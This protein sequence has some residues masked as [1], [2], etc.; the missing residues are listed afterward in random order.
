[1]FRSNPERKVSACGMTQYR[2]PLDIY[3]WVAGQ[4]ILEV[5]NCVRNI[6]EGPWPTTGKISDPSIFEIACDDPVRRELRT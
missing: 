1:M 4:P 2:R 6:Q 5:L 3:P